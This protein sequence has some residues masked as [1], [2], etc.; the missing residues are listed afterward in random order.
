MEDMAAKSKIV[1]DL[2]KG[3][4]TFNHDAL[5][6]A[7]DAFVIYG[8][9]MTDVIDYGTSQLNAEGHNAMAQYLLSEANS[10]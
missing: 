7:A 2:F 6:V 3:K 8:T 1:A 4:T 9:H 10:K 5:V